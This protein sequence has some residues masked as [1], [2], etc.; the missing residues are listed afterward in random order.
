MVSPNTSG[1]QDNLPDADSRN[2]TREIENLVKN[3]T[4]DDILFVLISGGGSALLVDPVD[5]ITLEEKQKTIKLLS[6]NGATIQ[7]LNCV[8]KK[9][10]AV[11]GGRL[12][13]LSYPN[14][15]VSLIL[16]DVCNCL[17]SSPSRS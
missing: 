4:E 13:Q 2:A 12:A 6:K 8:R 5:K 7:E 9:L 1:A 3:L 15:T 17:L 16:S 11:K 14:T 10:S